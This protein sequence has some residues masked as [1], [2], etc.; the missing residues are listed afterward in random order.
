MRNA[1]REFHCKKSILLK[2]M[3]YFAK[4][5]EDGKSIIE[6]HSDLEV[7]EK[8]M[9]YC[10][11]RDIELGKQLQ[12]LIYFGID[13]KNMVSILISSNFLGMGTLEKKCLDFFHSHAQEILK[14][15]IHFNCLNPAL[16]GFISERFSPLELYFLKDP[17]DKL[18]SDLYKEKITEIS[19]LNRYNICLIC[20]SF[21]RIDEA[22]PC[23][24]RVPTLDKEGKIY[25]K[26]MIDDLFKIEDWIAAVFLKSDCDWERCFWWFW[27]FTSKM[28]CLICKNEFG[29]LLINSCCQHP[30]PASSS[31]NRLC[32]QCQ[33]PLHPFVPFEIERGC[34]HIAHITDDTSD[35]YTI[36]NTVKHLIIRE[37]LSDINKPCNHNQDLQMST[38]TPDFFQSYQTIGKSGNNISFLKSKV[39][40]QREADKI[41]MQSIIEF[42]KDGAR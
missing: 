35:T 36:F 1:K 27:A 13:H 12:Y 20:K 25:R 3:N 40:Y 17:K 19:F 32:R 11:L 14:L 21:F 23:S 41:K 18:K 33:K 9:G 4:L 8:L 29:A 15:P 38:L 24:F 26:H 31:I 16:K 6:V 37:E 10:F 30:K 42:I 2:E 5:L 7:F 28:E 34:R 39:I 22:A